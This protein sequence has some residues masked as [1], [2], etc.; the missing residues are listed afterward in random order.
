MRSRA[1]RPSSATMWDAQ[2]LDDK[3]GNQDRSTGPQ[4]V[5]ID[6]LHPLSQHVATPLHRLIPGQQCLDLSHTHSEVTVAG[7]LPFTEFCRIRITA[8]PP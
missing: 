2:R 1:I 7:S 3:S 8:A 6:V 5:E 4:P